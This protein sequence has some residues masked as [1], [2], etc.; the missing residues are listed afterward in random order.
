[1]SINEIF[2]LIYS[3][4]NNS[5]IFYDIIENKKINE[6][7][8][9]HKDIITGFRHYVDN[10]NKRDL[11]ISLSY[12]NNNIKLWNVNNLNCILNLEN[13]NKPGRYLSLACFLNS[14]NQIYIITG[15]RNY[16]SCEPI[17]VFDLKGKMVK[18]ISYEFV[19]YIV[20]IIMI[21]NLKYI[22]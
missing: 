5:I 9:A 19:R 22:F 2:Y 18:Q 8:N 7:K 17:K 15:N 12:D 10:Y 21:N 11:I 14:K 4:K 3:S 20:L 16:D 1:M 6:I 13:I